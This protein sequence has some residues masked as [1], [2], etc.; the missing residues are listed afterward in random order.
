MK[1]LLSIVLI[2]LMLVCLFGCGSTEQGEDDSSEPKT[3]E[4]TNS[5]LTINGDNVEY[6]V[7]WRGEE[8]VYNTFDKSMFYPIVYKTND[9]TFDVKIELPEPLPKN[10]SYIR[11]K[12]PSNEEERIKDLNLNGNILEFSFSIEESTNMYYY[13]IE[14]EF[15]YTNLGKYR[16]GRIDF[17]LLSAYN[18]GETQE[19]EEIS[20]ETA[21][22]I[23]EN[24]FADNNEMLEDWKYDAQFEKVEY[25]NPDYLYISMV[26]TPPIKD[27]IEFCGEKITYTINKYSG[28]I[29]NTT[30]Q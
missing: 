25:P 13:F 21:F 8:E 30:K 18:N 2:L 24:H 1:K 22:K 7:T 19:R 5:K 27:G 14:V 15:D 3:I 12:K 11:I 20:E 23:V 10:T 28:E 4:L 29:I 16:F 26:C 9:T 6:L 17:A